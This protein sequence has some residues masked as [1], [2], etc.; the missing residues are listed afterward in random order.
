M[1]LSVRHVVTV[2]VAALPGQATK[3][4]GPASGPGPGR[5]NPGPTLALG[6]PQPEAQ[7]AAVT[8][9]LPVLLV[10]HYRISSPAVTMSKWRPSSR[11]TCWNVSNARACDCQCGASQGDKAG[12]RDKRA[13][14]GNHHSHRQ[15]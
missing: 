4:L 11:N 1:E 10:M 8:Q 14:A 5:L 3:K 2:T 12:D 13:A 15:P 7:A 6:K 9:S